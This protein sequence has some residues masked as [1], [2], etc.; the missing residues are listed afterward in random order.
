MK[1]VMVGNRIQYK[2]DAAS[3]R[4]A[5]AVVRAALMFA[6]ACG[7]RGEGV[8]EAQEV[9]DGAVQVPIE[10]PAWSSQLSGLREPARTVIRDRE[11]WQDFWQSFAGARVPAPPAPEIDFAQKQV[12]V[13]AMGERS[14]AGYDIAVDA[15]YQQNDTTYVVVVEREPASGCIAATVISTPATA[16]LIPPGSGPVRFVE[17]QETRAC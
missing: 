11:S 5:G 2:V 1:S 4:P 16:V 14:T 8:T 13:A 12:I 15:V 6:V 7:S 17:R 10:H 9:P 3:A